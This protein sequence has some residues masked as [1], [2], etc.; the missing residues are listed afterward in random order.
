[1]NSKGNGCQGKAKKIMT[2]FHKAANG[3]CQRCRERKRKEMRG[4]VRAL[5]IYLFIYLFIHFYPLIS[6]EVPIEI[7]DLFFL[8]VL[9]KMAA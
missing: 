2:N 7:Q 6:Q 9:V 1:M 8:G 5:F 4:R 3:L